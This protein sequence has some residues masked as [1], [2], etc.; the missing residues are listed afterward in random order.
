MLSVVLNRVTLSV[1]GNCLFRCSSNFSACQKTMLLFHA[2][3]L[4]HLLPTG[5]TPSCGWS[6]A[7]HNA[8]KHSSL[9]YQCFNSGSNFPACFCVSFHFLKDSEDSMDKKG[10]LILWHGGNTGERQ[11]LLLFTP[12]IYRKAGPQFIG[13]RKLIPAHLFPGKSSPETHWWKLHEE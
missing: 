7:R 11:L 5:S 12:C 2:Y 13:L 4:A 6:K 9:S 1:M 10:R 3:R 8:T